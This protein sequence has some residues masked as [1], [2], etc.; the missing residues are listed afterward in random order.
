MRILLA[1]DGSRYARAAARF[2]ARF[3][4]GPGKHVDVLTILPD[5]PHSDRVSFGRAKALSTQWRATALARL[6][7]TAATLED[8][9]FTVNRLMR[10]GDPPAEIVYQ[11][12][13]GQ[14]DLVVAGS[15]G[16]GE[17]P[18]LPAGSVASAILEH[19]PAS[20]LLVRER[21]SR[22]REHQATRPLRVLLATDG[23]SHSNAAI[24]GFMNLV[25]TQHMM[26]TVATVQAEAS[27]L[28]AVPAGEPVEPDFRHAARVRVN[29]ALNR[30]AV[31]DA[32]VAP[33]ILEGRIV[34]S[35]NAKAAELD[36]DLIVVGSA[37]RPGDPS[38]IAAH[39]GRSA[40]CSILIIRSS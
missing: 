18:Y 3:V 15:K 20:V 25:R 21:E 28:A 37:G 22:K 33:A 13:R 6:D 29:Q 5:E 32:V 16:R 2:L 14:Y 27:T 8:R 34:E 40:P 9:G 4:R 39:V 17:S 11:A 1:T 26:V 36:A 10:S 19:A 35:L 30:L 31:L 23:E 38:S 12:I 7:A 24:D